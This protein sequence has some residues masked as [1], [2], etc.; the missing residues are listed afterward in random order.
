MTL[1][2]ET[3][4]EIVKSVYAP[5]K[6]SRSTFMNMVLGKTRFVVK[7][8]VDARHSEFKVKTTTSVAGV[9][10]SDFIVAATESATEVTALQQTELEVISLAAP[11]VKPTILR[12]FEQTT[13]RKGAIPE[14]ARKVS[15]EE[16]DRMMKEFKF[17]PS[18]TTPGAVTEQRQDQTQAEPLPSEEFDAMMLR[19]DDLIMPDSRIPLDMISSLSLDDSFQ[20]RRLIKKEKMIKDKKDIILHQQ[21][22]TTQKSNLP[23]FPGTP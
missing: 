19:D 12:D 20:T 13:V 8:L 4:L 6:Q 23:D 16:V 11:D 21:Y 3:K 2:P 1:S 5:E 22:E 7:K 18:D 10:G 9:R 17:H 14:E 15:A